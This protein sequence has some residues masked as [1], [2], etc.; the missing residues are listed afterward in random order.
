MQTLISTK[1]S[2]PIKLNYFEGI[3]DGKYTFNGTKV[4][5]N[6]AIHVKETEAWLDKI[7][8]TL[9][10][11]EKIGLIYPVKNSVLY[12]KIAQNDKYKDYIEAHEG[13]SAQGLEGRYYII[14]TDNTASKI[15]FLKNTYTGITRA[16]EGSLLLTVPVVPGDTEM[17]IIENKDNPKTTT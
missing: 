4:I 8:P 13:T 10:K 1:S 5:T 14:E 9:E 2:S 15:D 6:Q 7:I 12:S 11:G 16:S 17:P 3:H